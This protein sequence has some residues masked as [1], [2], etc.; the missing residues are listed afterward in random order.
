MVVIDTD[1]SP[2]KDFDTVA[3]VVTANGGVLYNQELAVP[4][5]LKLPATI[6]VVEGSSATEPV[7]ITVLGRRSGQLVVLNQVITTVPDSRLATLRMPLQWLCIGQAIDGQSADPSQD[8]STATSSCSGNE[9]SC[10][11]GTCTSE[12]VDS[13]KL[14][15]YDPTQVFGGATGPGTGGECFDT[16]GC[17]STGYVEPFD[18]TDCTMAEPSGSGVNVALVLPPG[19]A[20]I[21]DDHTCLVPLDQASDGW[22]DL[23]NG[24]LQLPPAVCTLKSG[25]IQG[26]AVT[27][28]CATKTPTTPTCGAWSSVSSNLGSIDAAAPDGAGATGSLDAGPSQDAAPPFDAGPTTD[29]APVCAAFSIN[30]SACDVVANTGCPGNMQCAAGSGSSDSFCT[31]IGAVGINGACTPGGTQATS[32]GPG[33]FCI[34]GVQVDGGFGCAPYC[35]NN[36]GCPSDAGFNVCAQLGADGGGTFGVCQGL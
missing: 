16:L 19:G 9:Q 3:L 17:F 20:G 33:L 23:G 10:V 22:S 7:T 30:Q 13:T 27:T 5:V 24:R 28:S 8:D 36:E 32:C 4:G 2:S 1:M 35:C 18:A 12:V 31:S 26:V 34:G 15:D 25:T 29:A 21:C 6:G 14:P 11:A